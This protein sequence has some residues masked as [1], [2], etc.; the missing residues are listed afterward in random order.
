VA[1]KTLEQWWRQ[2]REVWL[3]RAL[4]QVHLWC[5]LLLGLYV[6]LISV[7]GS[8]A[9]PRRELTHWWVPESVPA[10]AGRSPLDAQALTVQVKSQYPQ[11]T[12]LRVFRS[13]L[14]RSPQSATDAPPSIVPTYSVRLLIDGENA[15]RLFDP[16]SGRD[17]GSTL[18]AA[19][20]SYVQIVDL[21]D[22]LLAGH[23]GRVINGLLAIAVTALLLT[24]LVMWWPGVRRWRRSLYIQRGATGRRFFWQLHGML[25]FWSFLLLLLWAVTG[26]YFA[27]PAVLDVPVGW[28]YPPE[29]GGA[30]QG[31]DAIAFLSALHFGRFGGWEVRGL[32][33][34][35]GLVPAALF[36]SGAVV[37]WHRVLRPW[38]AQ[39]RQTGYR[40]DEALSHRQNR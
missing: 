14:P 28:I 31:E 32:W 21:H 29:S 20:A 18:P 24:G 25:G 4:F 40:E 16:Y 5:G 27:F 6:V 19:L 35:L 30:V 37:W 23:R 10:I 34:A 39:Q 7:T 17:L 11:A 26:I 22:D 2:P 38:M 9:V 15:E 33:M 8:L 13:R 3:R 36:I 1:L 12:I